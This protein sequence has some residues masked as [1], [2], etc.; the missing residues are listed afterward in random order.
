MKHRNLI[1]KLSL[2]LAALLILTAL[3]WASVSANAAK[4]DPLETKAGVIP[5]AIW[6]EGDLTLTFVC[7][8]TEYK[9]GDTFRGQTV[10][11][12]WNGTRITASSMEGPAWEGTVDE[13]AEKVVFEESFS[14]VRPTIMTGWFRYFVELT[15][16]TGISNLNTSE[17]T[18]MS[19]MFR[20]CNS[21][22]S[23]DLS[24][25]NTSKVTSM[26][27]MFTRC[28]E[29]TSLDLSHFDTSKVQYMQEMFSGCTELTTLDI[30][31]FDASKVITAAYMFAN[32]P[33]LEKIFCADS[34]SKWTFAS[35]NTTEV[36]FAGNTFS[37][38]S[39]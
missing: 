9:A 36:L 5:Q 2:F 3:P 39:T 15:E 13:M 25:F 21:L 17:V 34:D 29:L 6:T 32:C 7:E 19:D 31:G 35:E 33:K 12:V 22:E 14:I 10:T 16:I 24:S 38:L 18:D 1:K 30:S 8:S 37:P 11:E 20:S 27:N 4:G 26:G 23:L 28:Y